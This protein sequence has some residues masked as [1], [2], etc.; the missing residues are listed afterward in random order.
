MFSCVRLSGHHLASNWLWQAAGKGFS[1]CTGSK[2]L[3]RHLFFT[4]QECKHQSE[5]SQ[6][7]LEELGDVTDSKSVKSLLESGDE[8]SGRALDDIPDEVQSRNFPQRNRCVLALM[9]RLFRKFKGSSGLW[10]FT[11][12]VAKAE[13]LTSQQIWMHHKLQFGD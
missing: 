1:C 6:G 4:S 5:E 8:T 11:L 7:I 10:F 13:H 9:W 2:T 3:A 12:T